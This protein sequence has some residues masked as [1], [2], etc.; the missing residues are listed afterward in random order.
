[1][2]LQISSAYCGATLH[3]EGSAQFLFRDR[4]AL[5]VSV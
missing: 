4:K 1:M 2:T 5:L 3:A